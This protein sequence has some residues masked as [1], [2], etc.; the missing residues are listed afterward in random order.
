MKIHQKTIVLLIGALM[1]FSATAFFVEAKAP[2]KI[3]VIIGFYGTPDA[4]L[5]ASYQGQIKNT[6][7]QIH[8]VVAS[9][10]ETAYY[11]LQ[12]NP[13]IRYIEE[14]NHVQ[15]I[16]A[17]SLPWGVNRIDADLVWPAGNTGAGVKIAIVDTG[18]DYNHPD[19]AA[20]CVEGISFVDYTNDPMDDY[21]HGT[22][23]A[24]IAAA[25]NND[26]G[27]IGVA[28]GASLMPVKVLNYNGGADLSWIANGIIWAANNGADVISLSIGYNQ[29]VQ[30]WQDAC[31]YAYNTKGCVV[32]A[33]AGNS[34]N[35]PGSGDTVE[36]PARYSS[37]IAVSATDSNDKRAR[38]SSTGPTVE[39]AAPGVS[40]YS[41]VWDNTYT[42][43]SGT[44][45]SC[46]HV[47]GVAALVIAS[48]VTTNVEVR[49][50]MASTAEDLGAAG[51]DPLYG[52]GLVDAEHAVLA[53][54]PP[55][56]HDV[57]ITSINAPSSVLV[58]STV[59]IGVTVANEG[60]YP[61]T[62]TVTLTD[63][64]DSVV[65]GS[66][67]VSLAAGASTVVTFTWNTAG[68]TLGDHILEAAASVVP[69]ETD[70]SDNTKT[71]TVTIYEQTA[72]GDMWVAGISW[73]VKVAGPNRF[74]YHTVSIV[75]DDGPVSGATVHST[76]TYISTGS[77]FIFSGTTDSNGVIKF[78]LKGASLGVYEAFVT[79]VSQSTYTYN[80]ASDQGNPSTYT[81]T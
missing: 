18:I 8:A 58:G 40:I 81:L 59:T 55:E 35:P 75:S 69:G 10:P 12:Q 61:E 70:I 31:D 38:W 1:I 80:A 22:H 39:L 41:T 4:S 44:S 33:A 49:N 62:T 57:A 19:L 27:V 56:T 65:I 67:E 66:Q 3:N 51:R 17:Q 78:T 79:D 60:T 74:L 21:G 24:G 63:T 15:L 16:S 45:M 50:R 42:T 2:E 68:E 34:G 48:G 9:I 73:S 52:Y 54:P 64:Y 30:S 7:H 6:M 28:P 37:V 53:S 25:V 11:A 26:I 29:H 46:P 5:I 14:D 36:Y 20:N 76:L 47:A 43:M 72:N 23:C 32:V 71:T 77:T 13:H